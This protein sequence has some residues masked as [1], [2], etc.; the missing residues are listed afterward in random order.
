MTLRMQ[1]LFKT[2]SLVQISSE[3]ETKQ[4]CV[5]NV[6][7]SLHHYCLSSDVMK[8]GHLRHTFV[9]SPPSFKCG[10]SYAKSS[11]TKLKNSAFS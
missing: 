6:R 4:T 11:N 2:I 5:S 10:F 8:D 3:W 1:I 7:P 9:S